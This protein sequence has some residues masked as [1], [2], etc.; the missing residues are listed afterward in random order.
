[1]K[2]EALATPDFSA[3]KRRNQENLIRFLVTEAELAFTFCDMVQNTHIP[4]HR[5]QL[6][7]NI[8][9]AANAL[10]YFDERITDR[11]VQEYVLKRA[12]RLDDFLAW[13]SK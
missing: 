5:A 1:M 6:L 8:R 4:E 11:S 12:A 10:R 13:N 9:K 3:L 2:K 7:E